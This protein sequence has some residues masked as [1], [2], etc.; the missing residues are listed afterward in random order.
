MFCDMVNGFLPS[1]ILDWDKGFTLVAED[2]T[3]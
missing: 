3:A 2:L 1:S